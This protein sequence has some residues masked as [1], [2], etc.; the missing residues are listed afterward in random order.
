ME[1][2]LN[3]DIERLISRHVQ[4]GEY[5][6]AGDVIRTAVLLL[7]ERLGQAGSQQPRDLP[8]RNPRGILGRAYLATAPRHDSLIERAKNGSR[9]N[10]ATRRCYGLPVL[11][12]RTEPGAGRGIAELVDAWIA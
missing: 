6:S 12:A 10:S 4:S 9:G 8:R 7:E 5:P 2:S 3:P 11:T 1:I